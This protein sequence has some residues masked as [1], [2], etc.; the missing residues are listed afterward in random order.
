MQPDQTP[1]APDH[2]GLGQLIER[3][4]AEPDQDRRVSIGFNHPHS[5]RGDYWELAFEIAL[6]VTV[7]EMLAAAR[8]ALG[9]TFQGWKGGNY[10]M[11]EHTGLWLVAEEGACGETI[12]AIL[13]ELLLAPDNLDAAYQHGLTEGRRLER[14]EREQEEMSRD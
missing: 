11:G 4:A 10:T 8:S 13:L 7:S 14:E 1:L 6:N 9:A 2:L 5:Y 3:L 12:G